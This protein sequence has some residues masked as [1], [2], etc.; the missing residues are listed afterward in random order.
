MERVTMAFQLLSLAGSVAAVAILA[1]LARRYPSTRLLVIMPAAWAFFG[2]VYYALV[3][4]DRF[5][6]AALLLWGAVHRWIAMLMVLGALVVNLLVLRES[7]PV[8]PPG[9]YPSDNDD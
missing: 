5:T 2:A 1:Y 8:D 9:G 6:P 3:L 7:P 4:A